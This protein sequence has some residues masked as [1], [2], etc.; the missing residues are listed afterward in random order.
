MLVV[1]LYRIYIILI[2]R[3]WHIDGMLRERRMLARCVDGTAAFQRRV[4][5]TARPV[6]LRHLLP[7]A[8][9]PEHVVRVHDGVLTVG[10]R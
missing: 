4:R 10:E 7:P 6:V 1:Y 5:V 3:P 2:A 8:A 9:R